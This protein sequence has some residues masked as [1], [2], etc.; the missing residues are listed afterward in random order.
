MS[1]IGNLNR[2]LPGQPS[3]FN[4]RIPIPEKI[5]EIE[6]GERETM[7]DQYFHNSR[8]QPPPAE[9]R[10]YCALY[11]PTGK[12]LEELAPWVAGFIVLL[13]G[14]RTAQVREQANVSRYPLTALL[15]RSKA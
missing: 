3:I 9:A 7:V 8:D 14:S 11:A 4:S 13:D 5:C 6:S 2:T 12:H 1:M 10:C 15:F